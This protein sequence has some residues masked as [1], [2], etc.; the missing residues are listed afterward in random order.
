[1]AGDFVPGGSYQGA[2]VAYDKGPN[3]EHYCPDHWVINE[4]NQNQY[5]C[6]ICAR[7]NPDSSKLLTSKKDLELAAE[8]TRTRVKVHLVETHRIEE[9]QPR[10]EGK[11]WNGQWQRWASGKGTEEWQSAKRA[12]SAVE[13]SRKKPNIY[14]IIKILTRPAIIEREEIVEIVE[15]E[16]DFNFINRTREH[17]IENASSSPVPRDPKESEIPWEPRNSAPE[18]TPPTSEE[19]GD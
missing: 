15:P 18:D 4:E 16:A 8:A 19:P 10:Q 13:Q 5:I 11:E 2:S 1:M 7:V 14:R 17:D 6:S 3:D 12:K 9:H